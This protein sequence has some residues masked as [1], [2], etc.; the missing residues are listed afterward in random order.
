MNRQEP[1]LC[2]RLMLAARAPGLDADALSRV[3][4]ESP[5]LA[6]LDH[7]QPELLAQL[8]LTTRTIASLLCPD[9][10]RIAADLRWLRALGL[11]P[12]GLYV[13]RLSGSAA[14]FA[15]R[16]ARVVRARQCGGAE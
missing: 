16:A 6:L 14:A 11:S 13:A 12:A 3:A 10:T 2:R 9:E 4:A 8:G 1:D 5:D 15:R 7:P